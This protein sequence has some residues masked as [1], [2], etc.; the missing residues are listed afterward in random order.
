MLTCVSGLP[1]HGKTLYTL[2]HVERLRRESGRPVYVHGIKEL[3]LPW[4]PL[5]FPKQWEK[6]PDGSIIVI[7]E[8]WEHFPKRSAGSQVPS[9]VQALATHRHRGLDIF[10]VSQH[11]ANQLDH[12]VRGLVGRHYHVRRIFGAARSRLYTWE[13]LGDYLKWEDRREAVV[14]WFKFPREVFTWYKSAEVHTVKRSIPAKPFLIMGGGALAV[15]LLGWLAWS[16]LVGTTERADKV[17]AK[18]GEAFEQASIRSAKL[19]PEDFVPTVDGVPYSAPFYS[20]DV[21]IADVPI[22]AG[23]GVLKIGQQTECRCTDQQGNVIPL[24]HRHCL[25]LFNAGQFQP[26]VPGKYPEIEPYVPPL[27]L[28]ANYSEGTATATPQGG[29][30][31]P[32]SSRE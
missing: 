23:C 16:Q 29:G 25:S 32:D 7:D 2:F 21:K 18:A 12:F 8:A 19:K 4:L 30:A 6:C 13:R 31:G 28:P 9:Y 22:V 26:G 14:E 3:T 5:E 15:A 1:G 11:P 10:L 24:Y 17:T 20:D 27:A